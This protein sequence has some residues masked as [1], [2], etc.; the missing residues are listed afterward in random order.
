MLAPLNSDSLSF[1]KQQSLTRDGE[2]LICPGC[3]R[4][5]MTF[6]TGIHTYR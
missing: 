3:H 4:A 5:V 1:G 2:E 6:T